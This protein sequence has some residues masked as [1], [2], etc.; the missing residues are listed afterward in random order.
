MRVGII[1]CGFYAQNHLSAWR[2]LSASGAELCAAC[3]CD[4]Q[5]AQ[6]AGDA[7]G[8]PW[9]VDAGDMIRSVGIDLV[10]IVT[11]SETHAEIVG[12][13][14]EA[15]LGIMV[16]KPLA[17]DWQT[18]VEIATTVTTAGVFFGVHENFRFQAP[19]LRLRRMVENGAVG[20]PRQGR[21]TFRTS[22]DVF[23]AQPYMRDEERLIL[24]D[25]G[26]HLFDLARVFL[27]EVARVTC[28]TRTTL[29]GIRG[30]DTAIALLTHSEGALSVID[31]SF[32][33]RRHRDVFPETLIEIEGEEGVAT[34]REGGR[35]EVS[36]RGLAW[37]EEAGTPLLDWTE[38][39]WHVTQESV[40]ACNRH[41]LQAWRR[42]GQPE[43][44]IEDNLMT[45]ALVDAAYEAARTGIA[46]CPQRWKAPLPGTSARE[47]AQDRC[48]G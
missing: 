46:V 48:E 24:L 11:R 1:G 39:P 2:D 36:S 44:H 6:A 9:F 38:R 37:Q 47:A 4:Q 27:G 18:C 25:L 33:A 19:I 8:V 43:T 10:D 40:L 3:D 31:A 42:G 30:E 13:A 20:R 29:S 23:R 28:E 35:I 17:P 41:A 26:I 14:A 5:K 21:F 12:L 15:R 45:Y 34:L 16:Q 32:N 7:F 22:F